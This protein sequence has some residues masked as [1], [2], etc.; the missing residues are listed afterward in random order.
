LGNPFLTNFGGGAMADNPH[1]RSIKQAIENAKKSPK[2]VPCDDDDIEVGVAE[3][4]IR[5]TEQRRDAAVVRPQGHLLYQLVAEICF[6]GIA[7][8][9]LR[10]LY[11]LVLMAYYRIIKERKAKREKLLRL[12]QQERRG[13]ASS[14]A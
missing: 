12:R 10:R 4:L 9:G 3:M 6:L 5:L 8:T 7:D 13:S 1:R 11:Q 2:W 14:V